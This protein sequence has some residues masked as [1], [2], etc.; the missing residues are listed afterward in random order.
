MQIWAPEAACDARSLWRAP[1]KGGSDLRRF[2]APRMAVWP[3]VRTGS[4]ASSGC[5]E[6]YQT[7]A[8]VSV[9]RV[10]VPNPPSCRQ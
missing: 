1:G 2:R 8:G 9:E 3:A 7:L 6:K 10:I 5:G 4:A